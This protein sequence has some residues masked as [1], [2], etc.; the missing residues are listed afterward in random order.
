MG[1][2]RERTDDRQLHARRPVLAREHQDIDH[3]ASGLRASVANTQRAPEFVER[4]RPGA[5]VALLSQRQ[6]ALKAAG[7]A[8]EQI[9]IVVELCAGPIA[10][11][12]PLVTRADRP[13][14]TDRDL[15]RAD[16]RGDP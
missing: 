11:V 1:T 8:R 12:Q 15:P 7:L 5:T 16:P 13:G 3:L 6:G 9:E 4:G 10:A 14:V 2:G